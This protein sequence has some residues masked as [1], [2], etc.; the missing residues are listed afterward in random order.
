MARGEHRHTSGLREI[1]RMAG[2]MNPSGKRGYM[3]GRIL[4]DLASR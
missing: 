2:D 1:V 4:Q 3:P